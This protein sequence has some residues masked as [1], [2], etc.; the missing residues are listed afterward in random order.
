[1]TLLTFLHDFSEVK[2]AIVY[3]KIAWAPFFKIN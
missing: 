2:S 3:R 1:M